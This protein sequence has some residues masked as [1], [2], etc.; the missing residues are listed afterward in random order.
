MLTQSGIQKFFLLDAFSDISRLDEESIFAFYVVPLSSQL[1]SIRR[2]RVDYDK[3]QERDFRYNTS[4][5]FLG[6]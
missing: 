2:F 3:A 6:L 5:I 4:T 1:P